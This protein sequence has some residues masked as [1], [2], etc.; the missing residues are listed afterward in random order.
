MGLPKR[1]ASRLHSWTD[2][3]WVFGGVAFCF[4][5]Y[6][7]ATVKRYLDWA[8][9]LGCLFYFIFWRTGNICDGMIPCINLFGHRTY[10]HFWGVALISRFCGEMT[11]GF[12][13]TV[14]CSGPY[15]TRPCLFLINHRTYLG[16]RQMNL[17]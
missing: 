10:E 9:F 17:A 8:P 3:P 1:H 12:L 4:C 15:I 13:N 7:A 5:K 16:P 6:S 11:P 14:R 2:D